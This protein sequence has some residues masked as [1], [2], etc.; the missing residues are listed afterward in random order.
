MHVFEDLH[1]LEWSAICALDI[2]NIKENLNHTFKFITDPSYKPENGHLGSYDLKTENTK[3]YFAFR[4]PA[5]S[6]VLKY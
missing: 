2:R 5:A 4:L 6:S 1:R 3:N